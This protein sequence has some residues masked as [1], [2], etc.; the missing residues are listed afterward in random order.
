MSANLGDYLV[1]PIDSLRRVMRTIDAG[2]KGLALVVDAERRLLGAVTDGDLRRAIL[3]G[4]GL[5]SPIQAVLD[6]KA[7]GPYPGA[8]AAEFGTPDEALAQRMRE[9]KIRHLPLVDAD[10]R[11]VDLRTFEEVAA[12]APVRAVIMAGGRGERL[13]PRT[14]SLPKPMLPVGDRPALE[15]TV[16]KLKAAGIRRVHFATGYLAE[17]IAEHFQDGARFGVDVRYTRENEP[18][19]TAGALASLPPADEPTLVVNGDVLTRLDVR[20]M[21]D[22]HQE[23]KADLTV[24]VRVVE[25]PVPFGVVECSG[26]RVSGIKEKPLVPVLVNAG[27]YL[28]EPTAFGLLPS[29]GR[30]D[31]PELIQR[32]LDAG[33]SVVSFPIVEY[34]IDIGEEGAYQQADRDAR[35]GGWGT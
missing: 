28:L 5:D 17:K 16:E 23:H 22:F 31:M 32:L 9:R 14:Q 26:P 4:V 29:G 34:W 20:A 8:V 35:A 21:L 27:V 15:W 13:G 33:K 24:G 3:D 19:G 10:G 7:G 30:F 12:A 6:R 2:A 11:V 1:A 18:L 25:I